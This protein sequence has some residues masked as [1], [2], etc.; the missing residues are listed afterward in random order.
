MLRLIVK[1]LLVSAI[2]CFLSSCSPF[3]VIDLVVSKHGYAVD[4]NVVYGHHNNKLD[5]YQPIGDTKQR[6]VLVFVYGGSWRSG[7]PFS[8]KKEY[9]RFVGRTFALRGYTTVI[10]DYRVYPEVKFPTFIEDLAQSVK[11]AH[12]NLKE[13]EDSKII[14]IGHSAGAHITAL[15][16]LNSNYLEGVGLSKK[17]LGGWIGISGPYAFNPLKISYIK[18]IFETV[19]DEVDQARP[20]TF[21]NSD[22]APGFLLHGS[23]DRIVAP[24]NSTEL[25]KALKAVGA[26]IS[27]QSFDLGHFDIVLSLGVANVGDIGVQ[28]AILDFIENL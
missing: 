1:S 25:L 4:K 16:A 12:D 15:L 9:Y 3:R 2:G 23:N 13:R 20:I 11:W 14:L 8:G 5:V 10:P 22:I 24:R 7:R 18:N 17:S 27:Y 6:A 19:E 28:N 21:V 26:P